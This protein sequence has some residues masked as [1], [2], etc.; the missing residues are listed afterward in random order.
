M[1][2]R[3]K[4]GRLQRVTRLQAARLGTISRPVPCRRP[5]CEYDPEFASFFI[6]AAAAPVYDEK[7]GNTSTQTPTATSIDRIPIDFRFEPAG[8]QKGHL[9]PSTPFTPRRSLYLRLV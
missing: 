5:G 1:P 8:T 2:T 3:S 6:A 9:P 7:S 4:D